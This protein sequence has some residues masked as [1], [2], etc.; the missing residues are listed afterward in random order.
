MRI[1]ELD[2]TSMKNILGDMLKRD[3]NN[4]SEY[5]ETVQAI[6]KM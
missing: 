3:P 4:Y 5:S 2:E 6:V 1:V